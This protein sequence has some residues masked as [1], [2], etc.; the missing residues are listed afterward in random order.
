MSNVQRLAAV[1][2][3]VVVVVVGVVAYSVLRTPEAASGPIT[4]IPLATSAAAPA[5]TSA[6]A[7]AAATDTPATE[8]APATAEAA[9]TAAEPTA[10]ANA[11]PASAMIAQIISAES[12][13][14]FI[15][16]EVL[17]NAPKTV[18]GATKQVAGE[19]AVDAQNLANT[20]IGVIQVNA[21]DLATDSSFRDRAIKNRILNTDQFEFITF[22][23]T[24]IIGLPESGAVGQEYAFQITGDLTIRDVTKPVTFEVKASAPSADRFA[25]TAQ[26]TIRYAD[27]NIAI[28]QVPQVASVAEEVRLEIDFVAATS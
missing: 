9:P 25:G 28:P 22:T 14:R 2:G 16:D 4:P 13:A 26:T 6:P 19:I 5:A 23:P 27:F 10:A 24:Q 15:I 20:R 1:I 21:R 3:L 7:A 11:A 17:N 8:A 18:I 12:E